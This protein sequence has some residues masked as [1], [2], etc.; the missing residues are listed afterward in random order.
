MRSLIKCIIAA[1]M[2]FAIFTAAQAAIINPNFE[3]GLDDWYNLS[4]PGTVIANGGIAEFIGGD[5]ASPFSSVLTQGDDGTFSFSAPV[6]LSPQTSKF[7][8]S[9]WL[10]NKVGDTTEVGTSS[11]ADSFNVSFYDALDGAFD[12]FFRDLDFT[13]GTLISL[14]VSSLA[15]RDV[16]IAFELHDEDDGFNVQIGLD[17]LF[18]KERVNVPESSGFILIMIG[19]F[20]LLVSRRF[21]TP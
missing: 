8:F 19:L 16:A 3:D 15:G 13:A 14:D 11:F 6:Q 10:I 20:L 18:L 12:L 4:S 1:V 9:L 2:Q 5:G 21:V 7:E 17:N